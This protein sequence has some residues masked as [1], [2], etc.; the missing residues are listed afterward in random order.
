[1]GAP[2]PPREPGPAP[3]ALRPALQMAGQEANGPLPCSPTRHRRI[4]KGLFSLPGGSRDSEWQGS[5]PGILPRAACK[6]GASLTPCF[7]RQSSLPLPLPALVTFPSPSRSLPWGF[8]K[9][10]RDPRRPSFRPGNPLA[11]PFHHPP[12]QSCIFC[13]CLLRISY[14]LD[15]SQWLNKGGTVAIPILQ[16]KKLSLGKEKWLLEVTKPV[17]GGALC[18]WHMISRGLS[19]INSVEN[20]ALARKALLERFG[21]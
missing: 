10:R 8:P 1:M 18:H 20:E 2:C 11:H 9:E 12:T 6:A 16:M 4:R 7:S 19:A 14:P 13:Q 21:A 17:S 3:G 5:P 15:T